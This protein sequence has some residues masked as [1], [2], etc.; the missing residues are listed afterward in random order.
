MLKVGVIGVGSMGKNHVRV[1]SELQDVKLIG[2]S[3]KDKKTLNKISKKY[4]V[5]GFLDYKEL[6]KRE[7]DAVSIVVPTTLHKK[8]TLDCIE[9][10]IKNILLEKPIA[11]SVE[12]GEEIVRICKEKNVRLMVGHIE[13]FN[14]AVRKIKE[15]IKNEKIYSIDITR[16]GPK[17]PR[18]KD[19]GVVVD[20]GIHDIDLIRYL[21]GSEIKDVKWFVSSENGGREDNS[22]IIF[23]LENGTLAHITTNWLTPLKIR[24]IEIAT[25]N[26][27]IRG[28]FIEQSVVEYIRYSQKNNSNKTYLQKRPFANHEEP[29]K[30]EIKEFIKSIKESK[31]SPMSGKDA[32]E[33]LKIAESVARKNNI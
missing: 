16:V 4:D 29:L 17:P 14:P 15:L 30:N 9:N 24:K 5:E 12:S 10:G 27:F 22:E 20:M 2:I 1:L 21:T 7:L 18:I 3:D 28:D 6:L 25:K 13:R 8:I 19:V 11:D 32:L 23:K 31:K 26:K 33:A